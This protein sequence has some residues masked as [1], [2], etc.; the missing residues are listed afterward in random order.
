M[1]YTI[2]GRLVF[3][4]PEQRDPQPHARED[5]CRHSLAICPVPGGDRVNCRRSIY[6]YIYIYIHTYTQMYVYIHVYIYI[7]IYTQLY[8]YIYIYVCQGRAPR[9]GPAR[10]ALP[11]TPQRHV[12]TIVFIWGISCCFKNQPFQNFGLNITPSPP[13]PA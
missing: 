4:R 9:V 13:V 5:A 3:F 11:G 12:K 10:Q 8:I 1:I 6:I 7:Y 2:F